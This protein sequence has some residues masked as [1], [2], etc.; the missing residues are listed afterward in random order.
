MNGAGAGDLDAS[1]LGVGA[2]GGCGGAAARG[3]IPGDRQIVADVITVMA[4]AEVDRMRTETLTAAL[5][6]HNPDAYEGLTPTELRKLL[7]DVGAGSPVQLG[8]CEG[9]RNPRGFTLEALTAL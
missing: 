1:G 8:P 6:E 4:D 9:E 2:A 5:A 3:P 7:K